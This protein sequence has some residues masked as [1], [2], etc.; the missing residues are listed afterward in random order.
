MAIAFDA[1]SHNSGAALTT[2]T[3]NSPAMAA[4]WSGGLFLGATYYDGSKSIDNVKIWTTPFTYR[5]F[6]KYLRYNN[7]SAAATTESWYLLSPPDDGIYPVTVTMDAA[8]G[9]GV[10][11]AVGLT[12]FSGIDQSTP[13]EAHNETVVTGT[14]TS[15]TVSVTTLTANAMLLDVLA[16]INVTNA[17]TTQSGQTERNHEF[18]ATAST[19]AETS[20]RSVTTAGA[21]SMGW[22]FSNPGAATNCMVLALRPAASPSTTVTVN[23]LVQHQTMQ[24]WEVTAQAGDDNGNYALWRDDAMAAA[25]GAGIIRI[26]LELNDEMETSDGVY[27]FTVMDAKVTNV[28]IPFRDALARIGRSLRLNVCYVAFGTT[29]GGGSLQEDPN[30]Y[31]DFILA[32]VQRLDATH[33]LTVHNVEVILEPDNGTFFDQGTGTL[34]GQAIK[35]TGDLLATNGYTPGFI[36]PSTESVANADNYYDGLKS[37]SGAL[38]YVEAI[39]YHRYAGV[40]DANLANVKTRA[41]ADG[42]RAAMLEFGGATVENLRD[43]L[44]KGR[45]SSWEQYTLAY[46]TTDNGYQL[47]PIVSNAVTVGSRTWALLQYFKYVQPGDIRLGVTSTDANV[48]PTAFQR[49]S[50]GQRVVILHCDATGTYTVGGLIPNTLYDVTR[51]TSSASASPLGLLQANA[52]GVLTLTVP[53]ISIVT[54]NPVALTGLLL[55]RRPNPLLRR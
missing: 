52:S 20:T 26:R 25:A 8:L 38:A 23:P 2:L 15:H 6:T 24:A 48:R 41:I 3:L 36:A 53:S 39:S 4:L 1:A 16:Y 18:N 21:Y 35:A 10:A 43:D 17:S 30:D 7:G 11:L 50:D 32:C 14:H 33:G 42:K 44:I 22:S 13:I 34:I 51:A 40:T 19:G 55:D 5:S 45:V 37:I 12:S 28:V 9:A 46:P 49:A 29:Y 47:F 27:D 54:L 31:A